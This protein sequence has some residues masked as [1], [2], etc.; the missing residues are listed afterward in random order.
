[1]YH[2][3]TRREAAFEGDPRGLLHRLA[4]FAL[5]GR[6][7]FLTRG[8]ILQGIFLT[9]WSFK[10]RCNPR[11]RLARRRKMA[12]FA[13]KNRRPRGLPGRANATIRSPATFETAANGPKVAGHV[14]SPRP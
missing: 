14:A 12:F 10:N 11:P 9:D 13:G 7:H 6:G 1:V 4:R 3:L 5:P 8:R 2:A